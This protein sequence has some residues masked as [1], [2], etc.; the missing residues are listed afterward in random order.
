M[1]L[2]Q[3]SPVSDADSDAPWWRDTQIIKRWVTSVVA[4]FLV[5]ALIGLVGYPAFK[6]FRKKRII[7]ISKAFVE[8]EDYRSAYLLLDQYIKNDPANLEARRLLAKVLEEYGAGQG[9]AEWEN[10]IQV[11]PGN[12]ANQIGYIS[13]ALR[14]GQLQK[15]PDALSALQKLQPNGSDFY[16]LSAGLAL[17]KGD[18]AALRQA[19]EGLAL[20]EP[21]NV[22]TQFNVAALR[23]NS[24]VP[25]EVTAARETLEKFARGDAFRIRAALALIGDAPRRWPKEKNPAKHYALIAHQLELDKT[26]SALPHEAISTGTPQSPVPAPG[27]PSVVE[28]LENQPAPTAEDVAVFTQWML[29]IGQAREALVWLE[30]LPEKSRQSAA[31]LSGMAACAVALEAWD[32]LEPLLIQGA[33]GPVPSDAV[34]FAFQARLLRTQENDSRAE[35]IWNKAI[36]SAESSLSGLRMLHRLMQIWRWPGKEIQVLWI[37]VRR[38]PHD[39][40]AWQKLADQVM[41]ARET[42]QVWRFYNAW[43]Q[44]APTNL[45]M[46]CERVVIGLLARPQEPGLAAQAEQLYRTNPNHPGCR[47]AQALAL[48][49]GGL[50]NEALIVLDAVQLNPATVPRVALARGLVLA[51]IRRSAESERM[52]ALVKPEWLLPEENALIATARAGL[53]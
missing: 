40:L 29:K 20:V 15:A 42:V 26:P 35:S 19:V 33:W 8:T 9:L 50:A 32:K 34:K 7:R 52:F 11:E 24:S 38:F 45:Q 13:S 14:V 18:M 4:V 46:Q 30:A 41:A 25:A 2:G 53:K 39:A 43:R 36:Q 31:G 37:I 22:T 6:D 48:W 51:A 27:L 1:S 5:G 10:L 28:Y 21:E 17:V 12:A 47:L 16:R 3:P 44:A 23:L 49:R